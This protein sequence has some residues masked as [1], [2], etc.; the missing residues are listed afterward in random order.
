[1]PVHPIEFRY[2]YPEM[3]EVFSEESKLQKW[4]DVEAALAW[5]HAE[6]GTIPRE[7]AEEIEDKANVGV[8]SLERF[9][10]IDKEIHHDVMA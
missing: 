8:V 4:L 10:E 9:K 7:T 3:R 2:F 1:M 6:L 5:T